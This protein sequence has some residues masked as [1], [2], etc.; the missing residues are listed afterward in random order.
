MGE[1]LNFLL[2]IRFWVVLF[3]HEAGPRSNSPGFSQQVLKS[4]IIFLN[5]DFNFA[6]ILATGPVIFIKPSEN[7]PII[8]QTKFSKEPP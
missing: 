8:N 1:Q 2:V 6:A 7:W 5:S 4:K 3:L